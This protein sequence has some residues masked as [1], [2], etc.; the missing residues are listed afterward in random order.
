MLARCRVKASLSRSAASAP[1]LFTERIDTTR[2]AGIGIK[3]HQDFLVITDRH[4]CI[5]PLIQRSVQPTQAPL[6]QTPQW[7]RWPADGQ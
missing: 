6:Q 5:A 1:T 4:P 7:T 2:K 3:L